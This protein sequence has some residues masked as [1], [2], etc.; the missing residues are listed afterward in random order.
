MLS[1]KK[2]SHIVNYLIAAL[3]VAL[4]FGVLVCA[5]PVSAASV[6]AA[7]WNPSLG[8]DFECHTNTHPSLISLTDAQIIAELQAVNTAFQTHGY[9][10]PQHMAYP[11]G[12]YNS[13]V[14]SIVSQYRKSARTVSDNMTTYPVA[15]WYELNAAQFIP[16][17]TMTDVT[18]WVTQCISTKSLLV[19]FTHDISN[20]PSAYGC[21]PAMLT[22]LLNYLV[23]Q[24]NAGKIVVMTMAAAYDY[25]NNA[26]T[27]PKPTVVVCFDDA[28]ESDYLVAYPLFHARGLKGTSYIV[29]SYVDQDA[30]LHWTEIATM[31]TSIINYA[32]HFESKQTTSATS[33][34]GTITFNGN[35][36]TL[37]TNILKTRGNYAAQYYPTSGY[38]FDHW[39][40]TGAITVPST[41]TN[42]TTVTVNS[43]GTLRAVYKTSSTT[44]YIFTDG[45]ESGNFNAWTGTYVT[46]GETATVVSTLHQSGSYSALFTSHGGSTVARAYC[47]KN[48]SNQSQLYMLTYV[49]FNSSVSLPNYDNLWLIQF[50]DSGGN[51]IASF[52]VSKDSTSAK[53]AIQYGG[54]TKVYATSGP[55]AHG[56]YAVEACF[57][58][59]TSGKALV[60]YINGTQV[61]ALSLNTSGANSIAQARVGIA[62]NAAGYKNY[63]YIDSV[64]IDNK[65]IT[66][67]S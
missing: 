17:T 22:N 50:R 55:T 64:I 59:T 23:T 9:P 61:A 4:T 54:S 11:Y 12:D 48:L 46:T 65:Y 21:T 13:H 45:F 32:L 18:N 2:R 58:K 8:W 30:Q 16:T 15:N 29:T 42:P 49:Y 33:N 51:A 60:I 43:N 34:T 14:E 44:T 52:G 20:S 56:W 47:Y 53:W 40:T 63:V 35:S 26:P 1:P 28:N 41:T 37:P 25:W 6:S 27:Q 5:V 24:Q 31:R 3:M 36:Y 62:Y 7:T 66:P 38:T 19:I 57:N 39:E 67:P 10:P